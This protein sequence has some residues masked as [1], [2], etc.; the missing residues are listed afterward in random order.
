MPRSRV[1]GSF[2]SRKMFPSTTP[3]S[4][5]RACDADTLQEPLLRARFPT[6]LLLGWACLVLE[7]L[8]FCLA[9]AVSFFPYV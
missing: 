8:P 4:C 1:R 2:A 6:A 7:I 5:W 3:S 9:F